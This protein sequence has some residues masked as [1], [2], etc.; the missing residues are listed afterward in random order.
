LE[1]NQMRSIVKNV[2]KRC[3]LTQE[4]LEALYNIVK[5]CFLFFFQIKSI[6]FFIKNKK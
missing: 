6:F 5:V 2:G 3:P 4:E 1:D